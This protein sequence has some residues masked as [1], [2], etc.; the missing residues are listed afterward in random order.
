MR[1]LF[2]PFVD[3]PGLQFEGFAKCGIRRGS[4]LSRKCATTAF[5]NNYFLHFSGGE[6]PDMALV[7]FRMVTSQ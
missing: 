6:V 2:Y 5:L 1:T 4:R 7:D 3:Q